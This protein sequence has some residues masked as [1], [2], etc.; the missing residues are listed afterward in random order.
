LLIQTEKENWSDFK[1]KI[2]PNLEAL[3]HFALGLT[4]NGRDAVELLRESL[5]EAYQSWDTLPAGEDCKLQLQDIM[6]R[7]FSGSGRR[8]VSP[9]VSEAEY[10]AEYS[11]A[12]AGLPDVFRSAMILSYLEGFS[13]S[14]I[15]GLAGVPPHA[16]DTL[17]ARGREIIRE[18][19]LAYLM[20][21]NGSRVD[22]AGAPGEGEEDRF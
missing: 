20:G 14:A 5:T 16:I 18:E 7:R 21:N 13:N 22:G 4:V 19:L 9:P 3:L 1:G 12:I 17:L 8:H 6:T 15:A 11:D 2:L 10:G